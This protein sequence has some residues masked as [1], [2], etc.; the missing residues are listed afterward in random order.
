MIKLRGKEKYLVDLS[1]IPSIMVGCV[2]NHLDLDKCAPYEF[3]DELAWPR[4]NYSV[5]M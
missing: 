5:L 2:R 1:T 4:L 3:I